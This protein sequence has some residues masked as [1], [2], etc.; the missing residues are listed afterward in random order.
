MGIIVE[1]VD[2][3]GIEGGCAADDAVHLI[4][5][6]EKKLGKV[7]TILSGDTRDECLFHKP[8]LASVRLIVFAYKRNYIY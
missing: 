3:A 6:G 7:R 2:P 1:M 4:P 5:L 8:T